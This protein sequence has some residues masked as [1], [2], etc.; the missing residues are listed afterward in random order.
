MRREWAYLLGL[1]GLALPPTPV[2]A[3]DITVPSGQMVSLLER[4]EDA[5]GP[6]GLTLRY[7]FVA[8]A[9][10]RE[11]GSITVEAALHDIDALCSGFVL[12]DVAGRNTAP[13]QVV[14]TLMD[15]PVAFGTTAPQATQYFEAFSVDGD[16][17]VWEGF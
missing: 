11:G 4:L 13:D 15:R 7:R 16:R 8:P 10:A 9:I 14:I 6:A 3:K 5:D 2:A 12:S 1:V 17:C